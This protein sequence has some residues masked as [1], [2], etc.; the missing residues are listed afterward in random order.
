MVKFWF[1]FFCENT[2]L[3][4]AVSEICNS[5]ANELRSNAVCNYQSKSKQMKQPKQE[6]IE[7][8]EENFKLWA[9]NNDDPEQALTGVQARSVW[10]YF[11]P[12]LLYQRKEVTREIIEEYSKYCCENSHNHNGAIVGQFLN[13][14]K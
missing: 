8:L 10:K 7:Q 1:Q 3:F 13:K 2:G 5:C 14:L 9:F 4:I 12:L 6:W 11:K